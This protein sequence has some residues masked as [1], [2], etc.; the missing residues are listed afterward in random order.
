IADE[1]TANIN[2]SRESY[3]CVAQRSSVLFFSITDLPNVDPMYQYSLNWF[4]NLF[5]RAIQHR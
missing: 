1:T 2:Q 4:I 3:K 5:L